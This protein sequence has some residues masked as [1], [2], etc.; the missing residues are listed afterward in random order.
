[1]SGLEGISVPQRGEEIRE[2]DWM[3]RVAF[4][5]LQQRPGVLN[6]AFLGKYWDLEGRKSKGPLANYSMRLTFKRDYSVPTD[7]GYAIHLLALIAIVAG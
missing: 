3:V 2:D 5:Q 4:K 7:K 6:V 1:M